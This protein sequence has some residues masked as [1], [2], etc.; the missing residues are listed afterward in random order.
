MTRLTV[1]YKSGFIHYR[2]NE[3]L[4]GLA[5]GEVVSVKS[6]R[7]AKM[8]ISRDERAALYR[9]YIND[10]LTVGEFAELHG[11]TRTEAARVL[12]IGR[13]EQELK[14][15]REKARLKRLQRA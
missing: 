10:Y 15:A 4:A 7:A 12:R 1:C 9:S 11:M 13:I 2:D 14:V 6:E 3:V 5:D 8:A